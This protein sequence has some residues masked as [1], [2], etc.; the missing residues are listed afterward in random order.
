[1]RETCIE[2]PSQTTITKD[3]VSVDVSGCIYVQFV[4]AERAAYVSLN[5]ATFSPLVL[6]FKT[7][8]FASLLR[9]FKGHPSCD[10]S[11]PNP[12]LLSFTLSKDILAVTVQNRTLPFSPSLFQR[13]S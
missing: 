11:K 9:P 5:P 3:N 7:E 6:P 4:D 13:T 8:P 2:I 1:M 12:P 10:R